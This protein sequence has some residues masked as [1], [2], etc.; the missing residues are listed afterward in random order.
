MDLS[1]LKDIGNYLVE[2]SAVIKLLMKPGSVLSVIYLLSILSRDRV[3]QEAR[4]VGVLPYTYIQLTTNKKQA[5][6]HRY[7]KLKQI[8]TYHTIIKTKNDVEQ[9]GMD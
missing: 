3:T 6:T 4:P 1:H 7:T 9:I 2:L 5:I 8:Q